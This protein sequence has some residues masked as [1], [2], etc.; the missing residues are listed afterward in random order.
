MAKDNEDRNDARAL[1]ADKK[2]REQAGVP[3]KIAEALARRQAELNK[4]KGKK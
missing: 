1:E 3:Y 4:K 2:R